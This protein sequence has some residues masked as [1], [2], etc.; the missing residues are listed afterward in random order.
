MRKAVVD[1][2]RVIR[3][4]PGRPLVRLITTSCSVLGVQ[5]PLRL[6]RPLCVSSA[7]AS[8]SVTWL[9][10]AELLGLQVRAELKATKRR[11]AWPWQVTR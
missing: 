8:A 10:A 3:F 11:S 4:S 9:T 7:H 6:E 1:G 2:W 5:Q